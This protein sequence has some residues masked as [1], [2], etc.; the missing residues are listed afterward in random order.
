[1]QSASRD[2]SGLVDGLSAYVGPLRGGKR[3]R[4]GGGITGH[5]S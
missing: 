1:M 3:E 5:C 2:V 4:K